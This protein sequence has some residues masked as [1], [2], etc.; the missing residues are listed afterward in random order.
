MADALQEAELF[1]VQT[2]GSPFTWWNNNQTTP[3]SKKIDHALINQAWSQKFPDAFA[4]FLEPLQSDHAPCVFRIPALQRRKRKP[5]KFYHHVADHPEF[6]PSVSESWNPASVIGSDQFKLV[7]S[8]KMLKKVLKGLNNTHF[9]GISKKVKEQSK[10]VAALQSLLLSDPQS[11]TAVEEHQERAK[12]NV[13]LT[14]EHKFYRQR[15]RVRWADVGDRNTPFFH[16][17]VAQRNNMN[18][19]HYLRDQTGGMCFLLLR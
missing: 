13:L 7:R 10:K 6:L 17:T 12:L 16:K 3:V 5:F 1:E 11:D 2:K 4:E 18:H 19:I 15:S 9:S 14:A 8:L